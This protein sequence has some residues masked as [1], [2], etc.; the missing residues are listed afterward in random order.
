MNNFVTNFEIPNVITEAVENPSQGNE[1]L[2]INN[3]FNNFKI[4]NA[5]IRSIGKNIENL[6]VFLS[7]FDVPF[8]CIVLTETWKIDNINFFHLDDYDIIYNNGSFNQNDGV[9]IYIKNDLN[10]NYEIQKINNTAVINLNIKILNYKINVIAIYKSPAINSKEFTSDLHQYLKTLKNKSDYK[11]ILGDLNIDIMKDNEISSEYLNTMC[12]YQYKSVINRYTRI[13]DD[14]KSCIDHIFLKTKKTLADENILPFV[15]ETQCVSEHFPVILQI[16]LTDVKKCNRFDN[17]KFIKYINYKSLKDE[18]ISYDWNNVITGEDLDTETKKFIDTL[19]ALVHKH[20]KTFKKKYVKRHEWITKGILVSMKK[21]DAL[22]K[23]VK[24]NP[25][26]EDIKK[27]HT[28]YRNKLTKIIK[29]TKNNF[30]KIQ[31]DQNKDNMK[32]MWETVNHKLKNSNRQDKIITNIKDKN[33]EVQTD[34]YEISN[35]FNRSFLSVGKN[36]ASKIKRNQNYMESKKINVH[37][38]F[39]YP[40]TV[41]EVEGYISE[42]KNKKAPGYDK[43]KSETL[44]EITKYISTPLTYLINKALSVGTWPESLKITIVKP[45]HKGGDKTLPLNYRPISL[46]TSITK[47][48]EKVLKVRMLNFLNK[49]NILSPQQFGFRQGKSTENA[50]SLLTKHIYKALDNSRPSLCLFIDLAKAFDTISHAL[51]MKNLEEIGF[52]GTAYKLISSYLTNRMQCVEVNEIRSNFA[53]IEYGV[54]QGTILGPILFIIY[55]NNLFEIDAKGLVISFADDTAIFYEGENWESLKQMVEND[56]VKIKSWFDFKLLSLNIDKTVYV[57]FASYSSTLP[58]FK[59]LEIIDNVS[60][61][62]TIISKPFAKY[63]GIMVDCHLKWDLHINYVTQ[64][65]RVHIHLFKF[66]KE[67]LNIKYLNIVYIALVEPHIRYGIIGWGGVMNVYLNK[68]ELTQ[69]RIIKI[70]YNRELTYPSDL[71][72]QETSILDPRQLFFLSLSVMQYSE[73]KN[74][75]NHNYSTRN[76]HNLIPEK[77]M[78]KTIG[79][80]SHIF[81][82]PRVFNF[83]PETIKDNLNKKTFRRKVKSFLRETS[84]SQINNIIDIKNT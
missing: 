13:V 76:R 10:Y 80:R 12:E 79:Q 1:V 46:I 9:M 67:I 15:I 64:K 11:V 25:N 60:S 68:L 37:S 44:K 20:T 65:L 74:F 14:S 16:V 66:L 24:E 57:P 31:I 32:K 83:L 27:E 38:I 84:R 43:I 22:Y 40:C 56:F 18:L 39:L 69:K 73:I 52:R 48:F 36:L 71:L 29:R 2:R 70:I 30:Y 78:F 58:K 41:P 77:I 45:V 34:E 35:E 21:R 55:L 54:P 72:Y 19:T 75:L 51:L 6:E 82:A 81:L 47:I 59:S 4:L 42:L 63:L 53:K 7:N 61:K 28:T 26:N 17:K 62:F 23:K 50:I 5:N 49:H 8:E 3:V 33:N